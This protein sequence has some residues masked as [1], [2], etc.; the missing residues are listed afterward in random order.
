MF[1][2]KEF[3]LGSSTTDHIGNLQKNLNLDKAA[4]KFDPPRRP[5]EMA[6]RIIM[7]IRKEV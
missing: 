2:L 7:V 1:L 6:L 5:H 4:S 3:L